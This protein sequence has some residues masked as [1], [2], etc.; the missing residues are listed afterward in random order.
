MPNSTSARFA[1]FAV[2]SFLLLLPFARLT[3]IS[4][5]GGLVALAVALIA[6]VDL[7]RARLGLSVLALI[8]VA[9]LLSAVDSVAPAISWRN[10]ASVWRYSGLIAA[11]ALLNTP[12]PSVTFWPALILALWVLD[13]F[14]QATTGW[15]LGGPLLSDRLSGIF[16]SDDLKLGPTLAV[17][18]PLLLFACER[19]GALFRVVTWFAVAVV[20]L[21]AGSRAGWASYGLVSG[22]WLW[23][24]TA[25]RRL[26]LL[27]VLGV[28]LLALSALV[29]G[30]YLSSERFAAR[31]DRSLGLFTAGDRDFALAGR[32]PIWQTAAGMAVAHPINGI[33]VR[34]FRFAYPQYAAPQDPWVTQDK[35]RG[36]HHPHQI[37]LEIVTE[38][39]IIGLLLWSAA[40]AAML[41]AWQRASASAREAAWP[42][43]CALIAMCFPLNTH[44]AFHSAFWGGLFFWLI[45][46]YCAAITTAKS[47]PC[48][49][50]V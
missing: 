34:A 43:A 41:R 2:V 40:A 30:L 46:M 12:S 32:L 33:G 26:V 5:L 50:A 16:G 11:A 14:C 27:P 39:G 3:E 7:S 8:G 21:L 28:G 22:L 48:R 13:A 10:V 38:T 17:L 24:I 29:S 31:V 36:A 35:S 25:G 44:L 15:S 49:N 9:M 20:L 23:R 1:A 47:R 42:Y 18:S 4:V 45:A 6:R 19:Y 37:L